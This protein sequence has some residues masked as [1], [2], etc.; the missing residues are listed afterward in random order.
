MRSDVPKPR[1]IQRLPTT[2]SGYPIPVITPRGDMSE[3]FTLVE[4]PD[5]GLTV[6]CPCQDT[7][8]PHKLG[9]M[10][11]DL[12]RR[13]MLRHRCGVCGKRLDPRTGL[14]F[15][16]S[17]PVTMVFIEPPL[18]PR[19]MAYA[20]QVCPMLARHAER[21]EILIAR[22][23]ELRER[24]V[25]AFPDGTKGVSQYFPLGDPQARHAGAL[26]YL[27]ATPVNPDIYPCPMWLEHH[28]PPL[29]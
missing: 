18:H 14:A 29:T 6:A 1:S 27:V 26:D 20:V 28:A 7:D 11:P 9:A 17:D 13:T 16:R 24:R 15:V 3:T 22:R 8:R 19:C 21:A 10:C 25:T 4:L 23:M 2:R 5:T 12:Q